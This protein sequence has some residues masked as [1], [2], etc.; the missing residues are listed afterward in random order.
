MTRVAP[1]KSAP[2]LKSELTDCS[3]PNS[4]NAMMT[5]S[6][7][8]TVRV[9]FLK[10][11]AITK[12]VRVMVRPFF[13][14]CLLEQLPLLQVQRAPRELRRLRIVGHHDDGLAV[15]AVEHLQ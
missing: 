15:L 8:S 12:L 14:G 9:R 1:T 7:V 2:E 13:S 11:F 5:D 4:T 6:S 3:S 10:R